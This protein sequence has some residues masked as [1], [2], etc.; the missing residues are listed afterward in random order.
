[1]EFRV[2]YKGDYLTFETDEEGRIPPTTVIVQEPFAEAKDKGP[3]LYRV[4]ARMRR[5]T[6][7]LHLSETFF[8][9]VEKMVETVFLALMATTIAIIIAIPISFLA[10]RNLMGGNPISMAVYYVVRTILNTLRSIEPLIMA[11]IFVVWVGLG[12]FAGVLALAVHSIA[13]LGKLYS[14]A[15]ESIDPGPIEAITATGANRLQTI[16]YA[17]IPQIVPPYLAFTIY[18]WDINVR[19]ST[20]IGFVGGGGI[21]YLLQQWIRLLMY[22]EAGAAVWA[23]AIVV[24][25]MDYASAK[26]REK[27]T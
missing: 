10:A 24:A 16:V 8:L 12:P 9:V 2:R 21:G 5:E 13:A 11:I 3:Q 1:M 4:Q 19:M 23:I 20:I 18:R 26:A 17:V 14:E 7:P 6:G 22:E 27:I 15:V 25:I